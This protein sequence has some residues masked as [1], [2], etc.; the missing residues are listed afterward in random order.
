M[1]V[2]GESEN[3]D[4]AFLAQIV[5]L[6]LH[7]S[8]VH[9]LDVLTK[10]LIYHLRLAAKHETLPADLADAKRR[11]EEVTGAQLSDGPR[12]FEYFAT[13]EVPYFSRTYRT[14]LGIDPTSG[15]DVR[16][17]IGSVF[18]VNTQNAPSDFLRNVRA[19]SAFLLTLSNFY[20]LEFGYGRLE[21][22]PDHS[23][24]V[25]IPVS[26]DMEWLSAAVR[27][28][29]DGLFGGLPSNAVQYLLE[30]LSTPIDELAT[31]DDDEMLNRI[32]SRPLLVWPDRSVLMVAPRDLMTTLRHKIIR[33]A[34]N[35]SCVDLLYAGFRQLAVRLT[36]KMTLA[37]FDSPGPEVINLD[38]HSVQ[39][40]GTFDVDKTLIINTHVPNFDADTENVFPS[41]FMKAFD[42]VT[43]SDTDQNK[44]LTLDIVWPM[45]RDLMLFGEGGG[46][47][48]TGSFDEFELI[49]FSPGTDHLTLWYFANALKRLDNTTRILHTGIS[50][51]YG[52]Y[53]GNDNSF[54]IADDSRLPDMLVV[55]SDYAV[56]LRNEFSTRIGTGYVHIANLVHE[57]HLKHGPAT[58]VREVLAYPRHI[59][60]CEI[61]GRTFWAELRSADA[62]NASRLHAFPE[63]V[64]YWAEV[65]DR[66]DPSIF[67][68]IQGDVMVRIT[69]LGDSEEG[70]ADWFQR[71]DP[72]DDIDLAFELRAPR[73]PPA[74]SPRNVLDRELVAKLAH[75]L[76]L[77]RLTGDSLEKEVADITNAVAP[78]GE[79]RMV[80]IVDA[81]ADLVAWPGQLPQG[82]KVQSAVVAG[83]LDSLGHSLRQGHGRQVGDIADSKRTAVLNREVVPFFGDTLQAK[84]GEYDQLKLITKLILQNEAL[85]HEEYIERARYP[86]RLACFGHGPDEIERLG[87]HLS[88]TNTASVCSRFLI[89]LSSA[90]QPTGTETP[91]DE[92]YDMLLALASELVNKGFLSDAIHVGLSHASLSILPSGRLGIAR[93][94]DRYT[95]ALQSLMSSMAD[96][97]IDEAIQSALDRQN[98]PDAGTDNFE[99]AEQL[100]TTEF[101]FSFT[102]I[103]IFTS[104][105]V[106]LSH[107]RDQ[108]DIGILEIAAVLDRMKSKFQWSTAATTSLIDQL[109]LRKVDNFWSLGADVM[110]WRFNRARSY[111]RQPL[112]QWDID[113][114]GCVIFGH[115]NV[116]RT[117]FEMHGQYIS[118]RLRANSAAMKEALSRAREEKGENF[119]RRVEAELRNYCYPVRRRVDK[120]GQYDFSNIDGLNLGDIDVI[121]FHEASKTLYLIEAKSLIVARTPRELQNELSDLIEGPHS[122]VERLRGRYEWVLAHSDVVFATLGID[123]AD[124]SIRPLIVIDADLLTARFTT[125]YDVVTLHRLRDYV[126]R[127]PHNVSAG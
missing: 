4:C 42:S 55:E 69:Y 76:L 41:P 121:A 21:M 47:R 103:S 111:L 59:F 29:L 2:A 67:D 8:N 94:S 115:R 78:P 88:E 114:V 80:H 123:S 49:L 27:I 102:Q 92:G 20:C 45:G 83:L 38:D 107:E 113:D 52:M 119:E 46:L 54:Y 57:S 117:S 34:R 64:C 44:T 65:L 12:G 90:I 50:A 51:V 56:T 99:T 61:D 82:R 93:D 75:S 126:E 1:P 72:V 87:K 95:Q 116:I 81:N 106:N 10:F 97:T 36:R 26:T 109:S 125:T 40:R 120:F 9:H 31:L 68:D 25:T 63:A 122:A 35:H 7:P 60:S 48:L 33:E 39:M 62:E 71:A 84:I 13:A 96:A 74:E 5:A 18:G 85:I 127:G 89:E 101:G 22:A 30:E 86:S 53:R 14:L 118:G 19:L 37:L 32:L 98:N 104:E 23:D 43:E 108:Y 100:A 3:D 16:Y 58:T 79:K 6:Q 124:A 24:A 110:P 105:L 17:L 91:T 112:I 28:D 77:Y 66:H 73:K 15:T 11:F 70:N